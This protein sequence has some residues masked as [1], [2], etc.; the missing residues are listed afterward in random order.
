MNEETIKTRA[1]TYTRDHLKEIA[2]YAIAVASTVVTVSMAYGHKQADTEML[3]TKVD[4]LVT[5][6]QS[7]RGEVR[8][9]S[10]KQIEMSG[11]LDAMD[12][13]VD[14]FK[15]WKDRVQGV[16]ETVSVPKLGHHAKH[17]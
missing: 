8:T 3:S 12:D 11:K 13:K 10:D 5:E 17:P 2:A 7:M 4:S 6:V 15:N 16:A 1:I 14:D 9:L